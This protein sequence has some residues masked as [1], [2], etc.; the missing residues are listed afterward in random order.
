MVAGVKGVSVTEHRLLWLLS[1]Y[2]KGG[3]LVA[4]INKHL[5]SSLLLPRRRQSTGK[6]FLHA[7]YG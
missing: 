3:V 1:A 2:S 6:V 7:L 5:V 4:V